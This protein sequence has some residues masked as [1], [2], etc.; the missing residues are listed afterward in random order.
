[1]LRQVYILKEGTIIY[2]K[3]FGKVLSFE[4]LQSIYQEINGEVS[5]GLIDDFGNTHFFKYR[6]IYT[7]DTELDLLFIF[8][9]G[10]NDDIETVKRELKKL[11]TE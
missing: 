1:M 10:F 5:R 11:K 9:I 8:I 6:I 3:D 2:E 7:V 4:N